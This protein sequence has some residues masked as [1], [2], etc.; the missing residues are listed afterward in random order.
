MTDSIQKIKFPELVFGFVAPIGADLTT[1]VTAFRSY[2]ER[3]SY[4]IVEIK[5]TDIFNILQRYIAPEQI[6]TS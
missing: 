3:R 2:F 5:V 1:T 4:R 6:L